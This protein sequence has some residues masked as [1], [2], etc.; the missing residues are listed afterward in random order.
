MSALAEFRT[1]V[2]TL[3]KK[4]QE[5]PPLVRLLDTVSFACVLL[6]GIGFIAISYFDVP[7]I[8]TNVAFMIYPVIVAGYAYSYRSKI[9]DETA[10][11]VAARK[12][13]LMLTGVSAV[14]V[15]LTFVYSLFLGA[16]I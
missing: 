13:F 8:V 4:W 7:V 10:D 3:K 5:L 16:A 14:I 15:L 9:V 11:H 2:N 6:F 12:E 1:D